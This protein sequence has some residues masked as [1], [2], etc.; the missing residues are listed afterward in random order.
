MHREVHKFSPVYLDGKAIYDG[1]KL[2]W[3]YDISLLARS[4]DSHDWNDLADAAR[5][6]GSE[7]VLC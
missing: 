2:I 1:N 3:L 5:T 6:Q 7:R 4:F